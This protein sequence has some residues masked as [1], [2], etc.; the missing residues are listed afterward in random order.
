VEDISLRE[1]RRGQCKKNDLMAAAKIPTS[2]SKQ[3]SELDEESLFPTCS[4]DQYISSG[5]FVIQKCSHC[6]A[7]PCF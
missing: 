6:P 2:A 1:A 4:R 7:A 5:S 3:I